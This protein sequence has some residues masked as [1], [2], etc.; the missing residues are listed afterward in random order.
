MKVQFSSI[1]M[2]W[3]TSYRDF[4]RDFFE[5]GDDVISHEVKGQLAQHHSHQSASVTNYY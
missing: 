1:Y 4:Y 2:T 3:Q 5:G